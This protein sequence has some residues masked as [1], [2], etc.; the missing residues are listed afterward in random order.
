MKQI[1]KK[2]PIYK[3]AWTLTDNFKE[4]GIK[5]VYN[6]KNR[7]VYLSLLNAPLFVHNEPGARMTLIACFK[8]FSNVRD[9]FQAY[10]DKYKNMYRIVYSNNPEMLKYLEQQTTQYGNEYTY[11][12]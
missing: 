10:A 2:L 7:T 6:N 3:Q 11:N 5:C 1:N 4:I 12:K 8:P 9:N